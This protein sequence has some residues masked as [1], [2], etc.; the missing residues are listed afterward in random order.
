M[1]ILPDVVAR[2]KER[3]NRDGYE[4]ISSA[5]FSIKCVKEHLR[6]G[7]CDALARHRQRNIF[8]RVRLL[9][10]H[11]GSQRARFFFRFP[12]VISKGDE[13]GEENK[14]TPPYS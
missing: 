9:N 14:I 1:A 4:M 13:L 12:H 7:V 2:P 3:V 10:A 5:D 6:V 8:M 11:E